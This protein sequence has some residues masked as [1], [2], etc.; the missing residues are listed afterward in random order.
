MRDLGRFGKTDRFWIL[1]FGFVRSW[2]ASD[3]LLQKT[4]T[5]NRYALVAE[6]KRILLN[7]VSAL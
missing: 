6:M 7:S 5:I 1:D 4:E 3:F 2:K